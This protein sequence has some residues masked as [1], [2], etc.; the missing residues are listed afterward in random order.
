ME[1]INKARLYQEIRS[2]EED[3]LNKPEGLGLAVLFLE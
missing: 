2:F 3:F 1:R